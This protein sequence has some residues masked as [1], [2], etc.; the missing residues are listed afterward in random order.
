MHGPGSRCAT[1]LPACQPL[2]MPFIH[3]STR[4]DT[5]TGAGVGVGSGVGMMVM[6]MGEEEQKQK[7]AAAVAHSPVE[8]KINVSGARGFAAS[9]A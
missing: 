9:K 1:R 3:S 8:K 4:P 2:F 7:G 5:Y 6:A